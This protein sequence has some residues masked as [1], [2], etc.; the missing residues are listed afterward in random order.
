[1]ADEQRR[2]WRNWSGEQRCRPLL[3]QRPRTR[4]GLIADIVA[5]RTQDRSVKVAGSGHSFT[6][7]ALTNG[8][9]L[10]VGLLDRVLD[11]DPAAGLVKVEAGIVLGELSRRLDR[12]GRALESLGD[13]DRQT[14]AGSISTGTHGTGPRFRN[15]SAQVEALEVVTADGELVELSAGSDGDGWRAARV[16]IGALGAI[17]SATLRTVTNFRIDRTDRPRPLTEV[18]AGLD[19]LADG[20]DHFEFYV[21]PHTETALCRESTRTQA[22]AEPPS[23]AAV[24]AQEVVVE[25]WV[26]G[27]F[28]QIARR[29]PAA[30]PTLSRLASAGT[31]RG[32]RIDR[33]F[34]VYASERRVRFTEMEYAIPREHARAAIERVLAVAARPEYRVCF[35]IEVRFVA[36]DDAMLSP[37]H[38]RDSAYVAVHQDRHGDWQPY[39]DA[40]AAVMADYGGRPHW[41]KRHSLT[42][43]ELAGLYPRFDDF[44]AVRAR[45]DP[46]GAFAN[47]YLERVLGPVEAG[48][49][50]RR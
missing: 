11:H 39:F 7:V 12:H 41:G 6:G 35:P 34:R 32:R 42:A 23:P 27:A 8:V 14:L 30:I 43:A 25:N 5:A 37:A 50:R 28:V 13:I 19:E 38:G 18:L 21:F 47:P 2:R 3:I 48:N 16:G 31:G 20:Y 29:L 44:R 24:Y 1:M 10:D 4:E 22:P 45:L 49:G 40:V 9:M 15:L 17:Y 36:G 33:G 26:A 46:E